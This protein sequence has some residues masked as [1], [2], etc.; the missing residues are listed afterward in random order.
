MPDAD[1]AVISHEQDGRTLSG[2]GADAD[3]L[4]EVMDRHAPEEAQA[5]PSAKQDAA[6]PVEAEKPVR[7]RFAQLTYEREE[8]KRRADA[9]EK[10][11]SE[12]RAKAAQP[13]PI[14]SAQPAISEA[15]TVAGPSS[16]NGRGDSGN[17]STRPKPTSDMI[18]DQ[19]KTWEDFQE[20]LIDWK[21][22]V[23]I[24]KE[25]DARIRAGIEADRASRTF[26]DHV[27]QVFTKGREAYTDFDAV[28]SGGPGANVMMDKQRLDAIMAHPAAEHLCYAV[29]RDAATAQRLATCPPFDFGVELARLAPTGSAAPPASTAQPSLATAPAPY[30]PVG[31]GSR[32]TA[33]S[34][35][36]AAK[37]GDYEAY[38]ARRNAERERSRR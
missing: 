6:K 36:D 9:A 34:S 10:E 27:N 18:G 7:K 21:N 23:L 17:Q 8:Q 13:A 35:A 30:Q 24:A 33:Q 28:R 22:E 15:S 4:A 26:S 31:S 1:L 14:Q 38:K 32:T 3:T 20:D 5:E 19:Y 25:F 12:L 2:V 37:T 11:L 29:S 16:P